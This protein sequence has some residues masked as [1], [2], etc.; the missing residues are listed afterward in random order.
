[1]EK[2]LIGGRWVVVRDA[3][4]MAAS[5]VFGGGGPVRVEREMGCGWVE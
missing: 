2:V 5:D 3:W 1:V 4:M